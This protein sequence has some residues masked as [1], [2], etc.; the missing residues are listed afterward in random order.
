MQS[1]LYRRAVE[2][3]E[4]EL[5]DE[6]V[7]LD[8]DRGTCFGFNPVAADVWSLLARPRRFDELQ[9][10]LTER[11]DVSDEQCRGE[12]AELLDRMTGLGLVD[13]VADA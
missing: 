8:A 12:L 1:P 6:L 3:M 11:Y 7:A 4:A 13:Q 9:S 2:L 5:G 10:A